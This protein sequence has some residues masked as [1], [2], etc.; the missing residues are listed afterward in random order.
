V[1]VFCASYQGMEDVVHRYLCLHNLK[2][3]HRYVSISI[4]RVSDMHSE[5]DSSG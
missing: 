2:L 4:S 5:A 1:C 3:G